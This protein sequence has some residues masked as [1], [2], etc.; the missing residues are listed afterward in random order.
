MAQCVGV[1]LAG[2]AGRRLGRSK[3]D[4]RFRGTTLAERAAAVLWELCG[5]VLISTAP[6]TPN[7]APAYPVIEDPAP[8]GRGPLVGIGA[9]YAATGAADLLV[10]ACDYPRVG[11]ELLRQV[12]DAAEPEDEAVILTDGAGRDH[13]LVGLWR[14]QAE[15]VVREAVQAGRFQVRGLLAELAVRRLGPSAL[16]E[17]DLDHLLFNLNWPEELGELVGGARRSIHRAEI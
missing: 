5:S 11:A 10:L 4:L 3:G 9:A 15:P 14:R 17:L 13:T 16:P 7:P 2:G 1:V 12:L 8:A 6:G